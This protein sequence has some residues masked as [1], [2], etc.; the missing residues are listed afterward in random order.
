MKLQLADHTTI[1]PIGI[2]KDLLMKVGMFSFNLDFVIVDTKEEEGTIILGRPFLAQSRTK[3]NVAK[4]KLTLKG[5]WGK[6]KEVF[7]MYKDKPKKM[8]GTKVME[9]IMVVMLRS[10]KRP[11][12]EAQWRSQ[13]AKKK[14]KGKPSIIEG[15][16]INLDEDLI[17]SRKKNW[18]ISKKLLRRNLRKKKKERK[19]ERI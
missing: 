10:G 14:D 16:I 3:I 4:G 17:K 13:T 18:I 11:F 5:E 6:K 15:T 19:K 7:Y 2:I 1:Q 12:E 8:L 9:E